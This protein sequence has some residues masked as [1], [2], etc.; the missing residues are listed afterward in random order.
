MST[1]K[2]NVLAETLNTTDNLHSQR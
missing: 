2:H 1:H